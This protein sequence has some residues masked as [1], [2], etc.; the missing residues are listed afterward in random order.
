MLIAVCRL[1]SNWK[2]S[3]AELSNYM[4]REAG[5]KDMTLKTGLRQKPRL[6]QIRLR[7]Q[8]SSH[9]QGFILRRST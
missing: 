9:S 7:R 6:P 1:R 2:K 4:K 8:I 5:K 3:G